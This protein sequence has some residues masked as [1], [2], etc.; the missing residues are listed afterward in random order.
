MALAA[1]ECWLLPRAFIS[2]CYVCFSITLVAA[3]GV[4][5]FLIAR[6]E[7]E[8]AR[9]RDSF[10]SAAVG[11][12]HFTTDGRWSRVNDRLC[13]IIGYSRE[14]LL[15]RDFQEV[16]HPIH[17][18]SSRAV[19][20]SLL[21][22]RSE[23]HIGGMRAI[24]KDGR[25]IW[26]H[27]TVSLVREDDGADYFL[28]IIDDVTA[29][30]QAAIELEES[31]N[32]L[33][34][35]VESA[36]DAILS[37]D[38]RQRIILFNRAA[39]EMFQRTAAS[40]IGRPVDELLP[41]RFIEEHRRHITAFAE[42]GVTNRGMDHLRTLSARR[43][44]GAEFPIEA[45]ISQVVIGGEKVFT[46]IIRDVTE[47]TRAED[48]QR[49]LL[50]ELDHRVKNTLATVEAIAMQSLH[51]KPEP[52]AFVESFSGRIQALGLAHGLLS[53]TSWQGADL[54]KLIDD[55]IM[56]IAPRAKE[57]ISFSGPHVIIEP[58]AA[59]HLGMVL[60]ELVSNAAKYGCL[61]Y[62]EGRLAVE[63]W[64]TGESDDPMLRLRWR[65][66]HGMLGAAPEKRG[67]GT[68]FIER[69]LSH[70]LGGEARLDFSPAG[71]TCEISLPLAK[72]AQGA[73]SG[74]PLESAL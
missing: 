40:I 57:R 48:S 30:K 5:G 63:W 47:R 12:A 41:E 21:S 32:R 6:R 27:V 9:L 44:D 51:A 13:A 55:Q 15:G 74:K 58:Q 67:F 1:L 20:E 71:L 39:E 64:V 56:L 54:A 35:M 7:A 69:S 25:M 46:A 42:T 37:I 65:E 24:H 8:F 49:L 53:R 11:M 43:A 18:A 10:D 16:I 73:Y 26:L 4:G 23:K 36:M 14:E 17:M 19:R 22:G 45:S 31:R 66:N 38:A 52:A 34:G 72:A 29:R 2:S 3:A 50:A 61:S 59:L 33:E 28:G 70:S 60:H 68:V 62:P